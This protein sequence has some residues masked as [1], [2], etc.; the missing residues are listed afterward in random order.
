MAGGILQII[1]Y[2]AQDIYL[3]NNPQITFFKTT[4]RRH[5]N[6]SI[7]AFELTFTDKPNFGT[8]RTLVLHRVG[9]LITKMYIK[10]TISAVTPNEGAKFAWIRRLG[11]AILKEIVLEMG[12]ERIDRQTGTWLDIWYELTQHNKKDN[13][14]L[15]L[16]GDIPLLTEY[17]NQPKPQYTLFIPLKFW[18]NR[19]FGLALPVI[20]IQYHRI[21]IHIRL[22]ELEKL[23][24]TNEAFNQ[25][26]SI[27]ILDVGLISD[28]I[29][30]DEIERSNFATLGHEY[31][32]EQLQFTGEESI[33]NSN[34]KIRLNFI[35]IVI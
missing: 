2:G 32:I 30:L 24:I 29:Y 17:N 4:Y 28:Y 19:H 21:K 31:L 23:I 34:N 35:F 9:D 13:G 18:F 20:G 16:I 27:N 15:S 25:Q 14:Y 12:G 5:T 6:F 3:T 8:K 11:H 22:T 10:I 33:S 26:S 1:A 7:Q